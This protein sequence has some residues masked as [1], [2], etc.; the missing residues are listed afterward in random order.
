MKRAQER[1]ERSS[2]S[3]EASRVSGVPARASVRGAGNAFTDSSISD[4]FNFS[5]IHNFLFSISGTKF[6][7]ICNQHPLISLK[8]KCHK[9]LRWTRI[10]KFYPVINEGS[11]FLIL[12]C[13]APS[14][15]AKINKN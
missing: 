8:N 12:N 13:K 15:N 7:Q 14:D 1:S 11:L 6:F 2:L 5:K 9:N 3:G 10:G 4:Y